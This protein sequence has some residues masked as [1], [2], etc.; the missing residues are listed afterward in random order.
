[1]HGYQEKDGEENRKTGGKTRVKEILKVYGYRWRM[2][3][4]RQSERMMFMTIPVLWARSRSGPGVVAG[5]LQDATIQ[6]TGCDSNV[7][8]GQT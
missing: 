4:T 5:F 7:H 2:Y 3:W 1:M 6:V 8:K